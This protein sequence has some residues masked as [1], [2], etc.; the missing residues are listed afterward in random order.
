MAKTALGTFAVG[1]TYDIMG[2]DIADFRRRRRTSLGM[3]A[4]MLNSDRFPGS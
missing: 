4:A 2:T 3:Y 1:M